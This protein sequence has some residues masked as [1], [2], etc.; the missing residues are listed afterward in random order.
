MA[1]QPSRKSAATPETG[2]A[3]TAGAGSPPSGSPRDRIIDALM[4]LAADR[5]WDEI[6][7]RHIAERAGVSLSEFRDAFPSKGAILAGFS[8]R[9]DKIVLDGTT[10]D[11]EGE[12]VRERLF[13]VMMRRLDAMA[14]YR[15]A[16][17]RITPAIRRDPLS[18]AA[19][20]QLL[21]N[22]MRFMLAAAGIDTSDALGPVKVQGAVLVWARVLDTW[23]DDD[24][25]GLARTMATLDRELA[26]GGR[27]MRA[28]DDVCRLTAP[29][30][31]FFDRAARRRRDYRERRRA[32]RDE[33]DYDGDEAGAAAI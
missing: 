21:S 5:D 30:R 10:D 22:S 15:E 3:A 17:R 18:L 4:D 16:L 28:L 31:A 8:R 1:R 29:F 25:P 2:A 33:E 27:F 23:L 11:L 7:I 32:P 13:D 6:E 9:L 24:D 26:R 14:P 20:N 12:S 19:M